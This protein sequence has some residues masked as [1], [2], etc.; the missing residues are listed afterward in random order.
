MDEDD[1]LPKNIC[2]KCCSK[3]QTVCEFIDTARKAQDVLQ[4]KSLIL[5]Q[6]VDNNK[7]SKIKIKEEMDC[8][9]EIKFTPME[10]SVDPLMVLQN[11]EDSILPDVEDNSESVEQDVTYLHGVDG[12]DVTIKLIKKG[13]KSC[14]PSDDK[15]DLSK[16]FQCK[17]C[18]RGF[19]TEL[20]L[21]NH[22]W[23]HYNENRAIKPHKCATCGDTF[24]Y[25]SELM[26]HLKKHRTAGM[27]KICGRV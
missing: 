4:N 17:T 23:I 6:N 1:R 9:D 11:S 25:K 3:L 14:D 26:L 19:F 24:E 5:E 21:K 22:S 27:C 8:S 2:I 20:A 10:V 7:S 18:D 12:E 15:K 16:P 13:D